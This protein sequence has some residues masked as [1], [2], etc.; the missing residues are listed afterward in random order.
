[1]LIVAQVLLDNIIDHCK[2][3]EIRIAE[4]YSIIAIMSCGSSLDD[5][6][7]RQIFKEQQLSDDV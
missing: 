2:L 3:Y 1:M 4:Y 7:D 5:D 6:T